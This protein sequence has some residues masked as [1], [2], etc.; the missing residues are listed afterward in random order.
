TEEVITSSRRYGN[1]LGVEFGAAY[2]SSAVVPDGTTPPP[3]DDP[4][5]DYVQSATPGCRAPHAWLGRNDGRL[6][7][8]DLVGAAFTLLAAPEGGAWAPLA[9]EA[10]R[11]LRIPS[12]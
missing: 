4:Y 5:S 10:S 2:A 12:A 6:S 3:V 9:A 7:T 8:L 1:H 11:A